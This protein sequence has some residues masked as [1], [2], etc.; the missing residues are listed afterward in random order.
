MKGMVVEGP[1]CVMPESPGSG[2][3]LQ[4]GFQLLVNW[5]SCL[6]SIS[7]FCNHSIFV[8]ELDKDSMSGCQVLGPHLLAHSKKRINVSFYGYYVT[9]VRSIVELNCI[10]A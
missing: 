9:I 10:M 6:T 8:M 3:R 2:A 1:F 5:S 7:F 4:T